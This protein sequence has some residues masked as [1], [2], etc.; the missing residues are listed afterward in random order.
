MELHLVFAFH[1]VTSPQ[2]WDYCEVSIGP[3]T[4]CVLTPRTS[5]CIAL[6]PTGNAN[7]SWSFFDLTTNKRLRRSTWTQIPMSIAVISTLNSLKN[8]K[9]HTTIDNIPPPSQPHTTDTST[10]P[11]PTHTPMNT[12]PHLQVFDDVLPPPTIP[13]TQTALPQPTAATPNP[14]ITGM[15]P[16]ITEPPPSITGVTSHQPEPVPPITSDTP[17]PVTTTRSGRSIKPPA[18]FLGHCHTN[19]GSTKAIKLY[20]SHAY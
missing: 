19:I 17:T 15:P 16:T 9:L 5:P 20:G 11:P 3:T 2:F 10:P 14:P 18:K 4:N 6:A 8:N 13:H 7:G 12:G 1:M